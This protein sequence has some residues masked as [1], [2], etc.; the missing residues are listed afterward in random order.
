MKMNK[1]AK[2]VERSSIYIEYLRSLNG[3]LRLTERELTILAKIIELNPDATNENE[4]RNVVSL[5]VRRKIIKEAN[6]NKTNLSKFIGGFIKNKILIRDVITG[7]TH[8]NKAVVPVIEDGQV[9]IQMII[10]IKDGN[11]STEI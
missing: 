5:P 1:F 2:T 10:K 6:I 8:L 9:I 3:L 11:N 7:S 4:Y